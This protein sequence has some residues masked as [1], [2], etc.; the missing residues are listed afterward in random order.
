MQNY[1][2]KTICLAFCFLYSACAQYNAMETP[3]GFFLFLNSTTN[4]FSTWSF[5]RKITVDNSGRAESLKNFPVFLKLNSSRVN[6]SKMLANGADLRITDTSNN[7]LNFEIERWNTSGDSAIWFRAP[8]IVASS[9]TE[10][11][12]YYGNANANDAQNI[13]GVWDDNYLAVWHFNNATGANAIDSKVGHSGVPFSNP[14]RSTTTMTGYAI[15]FDGND[16]YTIPH[17][18]SLQ[19]AGD[20]TLTAIARVSNSSYRYIVEKG[21]ADSDNY[22]LYFNANNASGCP[23]TGFQCLGYE[24]KD[25]GGTYRSQVGA[26]VQIIQNQYYFLATTFNDT[27]NQVRYYIDADASQNTVQ[28]NSPQ[29]NY[30]FDLGLGYQTSGAASKNF[31]M[32]GLIDEV[33]ISSTTRSSHWLNAVYT[34]IFSEPSFISFGNVESDF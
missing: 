30:S 18:S 28:P 4:P 2:K 27:S 14:T 22:A 34:N 8:N 33:R 31:Y 12:V 19:N 11:Y 26:T 24:F 20:I 29:S 16:G 21:Q 7:L 13:S 10:F 5:R 3:L 9:I 32:V 6:Y 15:D 1:V 17:T 23:N 25:T